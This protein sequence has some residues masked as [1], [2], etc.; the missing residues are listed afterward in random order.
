MR[1]LCLILFS[2][3]HIIMV[4]IGRPAQRITLTS[5]IK[6]SRTFMELILA[7]KV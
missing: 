4:N 7:V 2:G 3:L 5:V 6:E 1:F